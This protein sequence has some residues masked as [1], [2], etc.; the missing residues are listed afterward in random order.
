M[1]RTSVELAT[2]TP[3]R[4]V[5]VSAAR[6]E[7]VRRSRRRSVWQEAE[8]AQVMAHVTVENVAQTVH[9]VEI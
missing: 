7:E 5:S 2:V 8:S 6:R 4:D 9:Q 1:R 3:S